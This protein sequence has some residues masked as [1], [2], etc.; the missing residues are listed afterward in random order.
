MSNQSLL[1][2][3]DILEKITKLKEQEAELY[4]KILNAFF[5]VFDRV[6][7]TYTDVYL[8][9]TFTVS[10]LWTYVKQN[11]EMRFPLRGLEFS[12]I[13]QKI[14]HFFNSLN[15]DIIKLIDPE[16]IL[17]LG[18]RP[19]ANEYDE[20]KNRLIHQ[21]IDHSGPGLQ[22]ITIDLIREFSPIKLKQLYLM[23]ENLDLDRMPDENIFTGNQ[24]DLFQDI[25]QQFHQQFPT[26]TEV[27]FWQ[28]LVKAGLGSYQRDKG[29]LG[30]KIHS[31]ANP[32]FLK[33][34]YTQ[35]KMVVQGKLKPNDIRL[36]E[37]PDPINYTRTSW[38]KKS[39]KFFTKSDT[40]NG[41]ISAGSH[42][43]NN[44]HALLALVVTGLAAPTVIILANALTM[45]EGSDFQ[46]F[47][48][49]FAILLIVIFY[50][51]FIGWILHKLS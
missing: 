34:L 38:V 12:E 3:V 24:N 7:D 20:P 30:V 49:L 26:G 47:G 29:Y 2:L 22:A 1:S 5:L 18:S 9:N 23:L 27:E 48:V 4:K 25:H 42:K 50:L 37:S 21:F 40:K 15:L 33:W 45:L 39:L 41:N 14:E 8:K 46:F 28:I 10:T 36:G 13:K 43:I 19:G 44:P 32:A 35:L 31:F 51:V 11:L 17:A 16:K 6:Y